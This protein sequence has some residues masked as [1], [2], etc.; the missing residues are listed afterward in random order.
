VLQDGRPGE[1]Y[2]VGGGRELSNHELTAL[3]LEATGRDE[4]F[5]EHIDD[6]RGRGHDQR[7]AVDDSKLAALGYRPATTFEVGLARTVQWYRDNR[8]WWD[9]LVRGRD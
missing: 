3:L 8:A 9:P 2:N 7:Y 5:V 4:S 1:I 6:P